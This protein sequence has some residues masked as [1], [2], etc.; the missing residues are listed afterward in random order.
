MATIRGERVPVEGG[1]TL[2]LG[3]G[4]RRGRIALH[5]ATGP[6]IQTEEDTARI[7]VGTFA[8]AVP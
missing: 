1:H 4:V 6:E 8:V 3:P 7:T 2:P 5:Y